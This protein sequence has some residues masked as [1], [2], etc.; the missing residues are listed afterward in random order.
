MCVP[1]C[2][3]R[4][5]ERMYLYIIY[6]QFTRKPFLPF[7]LLDYVGGWLFFRKWRSQ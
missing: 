6:I 5:R 1:V 7:V 4:E 3:R 2:E